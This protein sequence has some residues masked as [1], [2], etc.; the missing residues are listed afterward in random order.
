MVGEKESLKTG[1]TETFSFTFFVYLTDF[2]TV[3]LLFT[4]HN[5]TLFY[6][7]EKKLFFYFV[8]SFYCFFHFFCFLHFNFVGNARSSVVNLLKVKVELESINKA[9]L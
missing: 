2:I 7:T 3:L 5:S 1:I 8:C 4:V 9:K 6:S